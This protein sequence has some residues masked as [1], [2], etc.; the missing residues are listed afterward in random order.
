MHFFFNGVHMIERPILFDEQLRLETLLALEVLDTPPE[1]QFDDFAKLAALLGQTPVGVI[2]FLDNERQWFKAKVGLEAVETPRWVSFCGHAIAQNEVMVIPDALQDLR[3]KDNPLV[4][5]SPYARFYAG[6]PLIAPNGTKIG[7]LCVMDMQP[8]TFSEEQKKGLETLAR[9]VMACLTQRSTAKLLDGA[10]QRLNEQD[11]SMIQMS[12]LAAVGELSEKIAHQINNPLAI[13]MAKT[14]CLVALIEAEKPARADYLKILDTVYESSDRIAK[15]VRCTLAI[16]RGE[17]N[18]PLEHVSIGG[19][20]EDVVAMAQDKFKFAGIELLCPKIPENIFV[21]ARPTQLAQVFLNLFNNAFDAIHQLEKRWVQVL[22][23]ESQTEVKLSVS[24]SGLG[25]PLEL[26]QKI[27][28]P[29]YTTKAAGKGSGLGLSITKD[30]I[31][32]FGGQFNLNTDALYTTFE[33]T[34][35]KSEDFSS[36][37]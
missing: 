1:S 37:I 6:A 23:T 20:L 19:V 8:R 7:T 28:Q 29:F 4:M 18:G 17:P 33:I 13:L 24:D 15:I 5:Q 25:I 31:K 12:R 11:A 3:F 36:Q 26:R 30:I 9:L 14:E 16:A 34:L 22:M 27:M 35:R 10:L 2:S 21:F 32:N